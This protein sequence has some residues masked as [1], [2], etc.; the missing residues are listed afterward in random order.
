MKNATEQ[1]QTQAARAGRSF[2]QIATVLMVVLPLALT[3]TIT[4]NIA[5]HNGSNDVKQ[6]IY[7]RLKTLEPDDIED[8]GLREAYYDFV[9]EG[10]PYY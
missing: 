3:F 5:Y 10:E 7:E 6:E 4:Y 1:P 2:K 9:L 8:P